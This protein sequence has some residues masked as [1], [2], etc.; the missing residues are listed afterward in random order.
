LLLKKL[1]EKPKLKLMLK[2][3]LL[4]QQKMLNMQDFRKN[5]TRLRLKRKPMKQQ[6]RLSMMQ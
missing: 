1:P 4:R 2:Q 5:S 3:R 6:L